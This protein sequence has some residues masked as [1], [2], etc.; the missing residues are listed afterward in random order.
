MVMNNVIRFI[1]IAVMWNTLQILYNIITD[2]INMI[3][4]AITGRIF[5]Y[6]FTYIILLNLQ[7]TAQD[8]DF[9]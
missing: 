4:V 9:L 3:R 1:I 7:L 5:K 6:Y 8:A 2:N